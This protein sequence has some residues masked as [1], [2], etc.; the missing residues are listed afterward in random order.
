MIL[1]KVGF[2]FQ[3]E[4]LAIAQVKKKVEKKLKK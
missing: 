1:Q 3:K 4:I 2:P